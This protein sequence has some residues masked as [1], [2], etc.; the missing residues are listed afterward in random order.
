[1]KFMDDK[2]LKSSD[3]IRSAPPPWWVEREIEL[4]VICMKLVVKGNGRDQ[5]TERGCV[6]DE[7]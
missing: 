1:M 3:I 7:E 4:S 2:K 6:H 5:N